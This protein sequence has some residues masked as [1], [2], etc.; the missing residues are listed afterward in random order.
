MFCNDAERWRRRCGP[1]PGR[2]SPGIPA[3]CPASVLGWLQHAGLLSMRG[4]WFVTLAWDRRGTGG[5]RQHPELLGGS[6]S[7]AQKEAPSPE[8]F[9]A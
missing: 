6:G 8:G 1:C 9:V 5:E 3:V 4:G 2:W 7:V